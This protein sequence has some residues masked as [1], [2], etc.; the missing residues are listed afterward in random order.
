[1]EKMYLDSRLPHAALND[2]KTTFEKEFFQVVN[3]LRQNPAMMIRYVKQYSASSACTEPNACRIVEIKLKELGDLQAVE[4]EGVA[5]NACYVNLTKQVSEEGEMTSGGASAEY[6]RQT[7]RNQSSYEALD[8]VKK[9]WKGSALDMVI[10]ILATFYA[11]SQNQD[12]IHTLLSPNLV[13]IGSSM[14]TNKKYGQIF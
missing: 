5:S 8:T 4:L 13:A 6:A 12:L 2:Y 9:R 11:S 14:L 7:S 1:M 10:S 3:L